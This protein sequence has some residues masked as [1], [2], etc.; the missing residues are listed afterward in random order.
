[1]AMQLVTPCLDVEQ[2]RSL[3]SDYHP[4]RPAASCRGWRTP[5]TTMCLGLDDC[6][7]MR[8]ATCMLCR[9]SSGLCQRGSSA[10]MHHVRAPQPAQLSQHRLRLSAGMLTERQTQRQE[11]AHWAV[12][13]EWSTPAG[14]QSL[15]HDA[16]G[17]AAEGGYMPYDVPRTEQDRTSRH[18]GDHQLNPRDRDQVTAQHFNLGEASPCATLTTDSSSP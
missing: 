11:C 7:N 13:V 12:L 8:C 15:A 3:R 18:F 10:A 16:V 2:E 5:H 4:L 6:C 1:M 17:A 14:S 9:H